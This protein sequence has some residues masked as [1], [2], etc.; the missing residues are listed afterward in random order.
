[1]ALSRLKWI[2][3]GFLSI[4]VP[5]GLLATFRLTGVLQE[6]PKPETITIES[7][8]WNMSRPI[9]LLDPI[10]VAE[11][12]ENSY[13]DGLASVRLGI[14]VD[15]YHEN[16]K[17]Y[18]FGKDILVFA[19]YVNASISEGF[20]ESMDVYFREEGNSCMVWLYR[21]PDWI[22]LVNLKVTNIIDRYN[23]MENYV[24]ACIKTVGLNQP[25]Y[26]YMWRPVGWNLLDEN[27]SDHELEITLELSYRYGSVYRK[28]V[29]PIVLTIYAEEP[30]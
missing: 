22:T 7:V 29:I 21:D 3:L 25:K 8:D 10:V 19:V 30:V 20:I 11:K 23:A 14:I 13:T 6:S 2:F 4:M 26:V 24:K 9:D 17:I 15:H 1:M 16:D 27:D 18:G 28:V 12:I 5:I